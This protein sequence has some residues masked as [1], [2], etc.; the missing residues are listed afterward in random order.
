M[1][2]IKNHYY[3]MAIDVVYETDT[4]QERQVFNVIRVCEH[5]YINRKQLELAQQSAQVRFKTEVKGADK[6]KVVDCC[7][8]SINYMGYMA[9]GEFHEG[10]EIPKPTPT[11][12]TTLKEILDKK[13]PDVQLNN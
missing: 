5:N 11:M 1:E 8:M 13:A 2:N 12:S 9:L 4:Y 7:I 3:L 6:L 10:Y